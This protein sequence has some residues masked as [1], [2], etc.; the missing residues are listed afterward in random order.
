[1]IIHAPKRR[2]RLPWFAVCDS[3]GEVFG[4]FDPGAV[5]FETPATVRGSDRLQLARASDLILNEAYGGWE[6]LQ[7][8]LCFL[9]PG[10]VALWRRFQEFGIVPEQTPALAGLAGGLDVPAFL[11]DGGAT[12]MGLHVDDSH[13]GTTIDGYPGPVNS[14]QSGQGPGLGH[15]GLSGDDKGGGGGGYGTAGA[16]G[17][18]FSDSNPVSFNLGRGGLQVS[19]IGVIECLIENTFT[20]ALLGHG[21]SG[22][23]S[24]NTP[25]GV[26]S[27][28]GSAYIEIP[29]S[30]MITT[31][32]RSLGGAAGNSPTGSGNRNGG[33]GGAGG[34]WVGVARRITYG[35]GAIDVSGGDGGAARGNGGVG[36]DGGDGRVVQLY[37]DGFASNLMVTGGVQNQFRLLRSPT[38]GLAAFL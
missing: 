29:P 19:A 11:G 17:G 31:I 8:A 27:E 18:N 36:G 32:A 13:D 26:E 25:T 34:L 4:P 6:R 14:N 3:T 12:G 20:H 28:G 37:F 9:Q 24:T 35:S 21:S 15:R 1:M 38:G 10:G 33:G 16:N 22:G 23:S 30:G 5:W 2:E 7:R